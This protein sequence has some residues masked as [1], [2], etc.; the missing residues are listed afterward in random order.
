MRVFLEIH[1]T[2]PYDPSPPPLVRVDVTGMDRLT[3]ET[4]AVALLETVGFIKPRVYVHYCYHE[5]GRLCRIEKLD[6]GA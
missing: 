3:I 1:E 2:E 6:L 5:E 4:L